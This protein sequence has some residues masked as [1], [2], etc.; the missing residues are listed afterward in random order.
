MP[1]APEALRPTRVLIVTEHASARFGGEAA[2]PLHYFRVLRSRGLP[3][4]LVTHSRVRAELQATFP[5]EAAR[6]H[7]IE[8]GAAHRFLWRLGQWLPDRLSYLSTG[9]ASR[10]ITQRRQRALARALV[11]E[12]QID[13]VHQP[14]PVSPKEPS[15]LHGLGVPV[16]MGPLNGAMDYPPAFRRRQARWVESF[17]SMARRASGVL[18]RIMQGKLRAAVVLVANERSR[19]GLPPGL[20]GRVAVLP[21]NGVDLALWHMAPGRKSNLGMVRFA[22][23]GRLVS[24]KAVD[25]L[26]EAFALARTAAPMS[27]TVVGDGP[28][29]VALQ[30]KARA[31]GLP[32]DPACGAGTVYFAGWRPQAE[33]AHLLAEHDALVLPS[34]H[35]CGGAVVLEAMACGL[36]V[37][38]TAW[39][40]PLDYLDE[41]CGILVEPRS[42]D[43]LVRGLA[44]ALERLA[45][46]PE[47]RGRLGRAG[48]ARIE[49]EFDWERKVD[50]MLGIY[51][52]A[53][54]ERGVGTD[55][56][57]DQG[58]VA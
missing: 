26:I 50:R 28:E 30:G 48:R 4:W 21:E 34:L 37:V 8:D 35:E 14:I 22:F 31:L 49:R 55:A 23:V 51:R 42:R 32:D 10:I 11:R 16:V 13:V 5:D 39:G 18:N 15:L 33:C 40:G 38:A 57:E 44:D 24:L 7:Y 2:L 17:S 36:P 45:L 29:L 56:G 47:L 9:F 20:T 27:L 58:A 19:A 43:A 1:S 3:V 41:S 12:H 53:A 25:L 54:A 6:I 46:G 52:S